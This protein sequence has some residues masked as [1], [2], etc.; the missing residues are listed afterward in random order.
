MANI[1]RIIDNGMCLGC[2]LCEAVGDLRM[3]ISENGFYRPLVIPTDKD[4]TGKIW[5]LCPGIRIENKNKS[6]T[7]VW[8]HI[9]MVANAWAKD[10]SIRQCSSSG[11][12]ISSLAIYLLESHK[13]DGV[14]HIGSIEGDYLH[15]KLFVSRTREDVL[16]R[17]ASRYAPALV[18]SEIFKILESTG[19]DTFAFIGKP[20]DIAA[21]RNLQEEYLLFK[22]R[23]PYCLAIFCAGMPSYNATER[24]ISTFN[25]Q[26]T[27]VSLRYRGD[28]WPG[29]FKVD[30]EDGSSFKM[31]YNDSWGKILGRDLG[32]RCKICADGIG[33]LA[34]IACGDAWHT[35]D[36]YPDFTES[37]GCNFCFI[38]TQK[39][40]SLFENA[41]R[42]GYLENEELNIDEVKD[43]QRYQYNR[44][45]YVGWSIGMVQLL[46]FHI[47]HWSGLGYYRIALKANIVQG[48]K[49]AR[50]TAKRFLKLKWEVARK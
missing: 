3:Q 26:G 48:I 46:S 33:L 19:D 44:R 11:G 9:E 14:L 12:V 25:H 40:K 43:M 34:D 50:G 24:V 6:N 45:H 5:K 21:I 1:K 49:Y 38:R 37:D 10:S 36:G 30:Y 13:V 32:F 15:N 47:L 8:G 20:C 29:F 39:G 22:E 31:T 16:K 27:P 4:T 17:S 18:F 42:C 23:I 41:V 2:G 7:E 35:K 28:G